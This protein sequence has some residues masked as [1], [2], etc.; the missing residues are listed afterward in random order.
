MPRAECLVTEES[1]L[2]EGPVWNRTS[3]EFFWVDIPSG[4]VFASDLTGSTRLIRQHAM[5][6]GSIVLT[7]N[8]E[9][10][11]STPVGLADERG[12]VR[13]PL[14]QT[15]C[16][17]RT[18][19]GK[20]DPAGRFVCGTMTVGDPPPASGRL[21]S[22]ASGE[23][24]LIV[25]SATIPNGLAWSGDG[26]VLHWIDTPTQKVFAFD[27]DLESGVLSNRRTHIAIPAEW[28]APDGMTIDADG[29]LWIAMWAGSSVR[30]FEGS[31]CVEKVEVPARLVTSVAF[32]GPK[33]DQLVITAASVD[34]SAEGSLFHHPPGCNGLNPHTVGAWADR[35]RSE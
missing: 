1:Q 15:A 24:T 27:Y 3:G 31:K 11:A 6:V 21:W 35:T 25:E 10:L 2:A 32:G 19:D 30:A 7:E 16:D 23:P 22:I 34:G 13:A 33:L 17:V 12:E 29:R 28:G 8:G 18:N 4:K 5:P 26:R 9:L 20:A 14:R